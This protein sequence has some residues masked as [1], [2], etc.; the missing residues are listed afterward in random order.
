MVELP[1]K[2]YD[3]I[4]T[5][6]QEG[7]PDEVCGLIGGKGRAEQTYRITNTAETPR[8][9]YVMQ[10]EEQF[11]VMMEIEDQGGDLY[12]IYHSHPSSEAYPSKTDR[13]LAFYPDAVYLICSLADRERP[14]L[15]AFRIVDDEVSEQELRIA[16]E[17]PVGS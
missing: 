17:V 2:L 8:V 7:W 5:H 3:E 15:R 12:G 6:A 14:V 13:S 1:R 16:D 9:L 11:R 4:V 10:P